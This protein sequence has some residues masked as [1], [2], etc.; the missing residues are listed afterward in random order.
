MGD[1]IDVDKVE[2]PPLRGS[3]VDRKG[4]AL[5]WWG[6]GGSEGPEMTKWRS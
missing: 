5:L 2:A 3:G 6:W 4:A 1:Q